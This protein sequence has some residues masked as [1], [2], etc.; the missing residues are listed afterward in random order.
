MSDGEIRKI[1]V[2]HS[3]GSPIPGD[4]ADLVIEVPP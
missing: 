1:S 3:Y 4:P 2:L